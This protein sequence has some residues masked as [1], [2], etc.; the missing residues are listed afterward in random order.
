MSGGSSGL[1]DASF[2]DVGRGRSTRRRHRNASGSR[3]FQI[4]PKVVGKSGIRR[5][6]LAQAG[7]SVS[8]SGRQLRPGRLRHLLQAGQVRYAQHR[9]ENR[10]SLESANKPSTQ[11]FVFL[12]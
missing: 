8:L 3:P 7:F 12:D 2:P 1:A 5:S 10:G 9:Q 6:L 4:P 11:L